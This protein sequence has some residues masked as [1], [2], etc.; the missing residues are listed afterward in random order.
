[1]P[2]DF[3]K[4]KSLKSLHLAVNKFKRIPVCISCMT[5]LSFLDLT[6]NKLE[7]LKIESIKAEKEETN[8]FLNLRFL[9][10]FNNLIHELELDSC[11]DLLANLHEFWFGNNQIQVIPCEIVRFKNMDWKN[12][13][14]SII[15]DENP[16][17]TPP[18]NVCK[19]GFASI[20]K[21]YIENKKSE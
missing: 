2:D 14:F 8:F 12:K 4:L 10:V 13:Y 6:S 11:Q 17:K 16:I 20:K 18:L 21:W 9:S 3:G 5:N 1:M 15:L 7:T 19:D